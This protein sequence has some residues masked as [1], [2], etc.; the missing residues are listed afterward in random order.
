MGR[1]LSDLKLK[2]MLIFLFMQFFLTVHLVPVN[3]N[4]RQFGKIN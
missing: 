3:E 1:I 4:R 2:M